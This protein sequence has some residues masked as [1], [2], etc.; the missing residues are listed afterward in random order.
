MPALL[1]PIWSTGEQYEK[2][3]AEA[4]EVLKVLEEELMV[5]GK[6]FF[7]GDSIGAVDI[8]ANFIG[9]S[10][11]AIE[12]A[13]GLD[14]FTKEKF[15]RLWEWADD[16][17]DCGIIKEHLPSKQNLIA[18]FPPRYW[19]EDVVTRFQSRVASHSRATAA[20]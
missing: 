4:C 13:I 19:G 5:K 1:K 14:V 11:R 16:F 2:D 20:E 18:N 17:V 12:E 3:K 9:F 7:G 6:K 15:P 10:H 8:V